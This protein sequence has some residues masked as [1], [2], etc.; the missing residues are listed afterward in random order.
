V[1]KSVVKVYSDAACCEFEPGTTSDPKQ[2]VCRPSTISKAKAPTNYVPETF[3]PSGSSHISPGPRSMGL[4][5]S[6]KEREDESIE[7]DR[8]LKPSAKQIV[9]DRPKAMNCCGS[10]RE[11]GNEPKAQPGK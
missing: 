3:R 2:T 11:I 1:I 5:H 8:R 4:A 6:Q 7:V 10:I 9:N